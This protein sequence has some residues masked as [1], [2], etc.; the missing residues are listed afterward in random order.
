[1][2]R[3]KYLKCVDGDDVETNVG[4]VECVFFM[5]NPMMQIA[6]SG[7]SAVTKFERSKLEVEF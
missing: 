2:R 1:M 7:Q 6:Q 5:K 3:E 4:Y